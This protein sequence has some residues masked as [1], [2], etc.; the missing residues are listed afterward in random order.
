[1]NIIWKFRN[2]HQTDQT[3]N[4]DFI[5]LP[6]FLYNADVVAC[7]IGYWGYIYGG[8]LTTRPENSLRPY[9]NETKCPV[10]LLLL[11]HSQLKAVHRSEGVVMPGEARPGVC[12]EVSD[13][14][15]H[16]SDNVTCKGQV[17]SLSVPFLSFDGN[18]PI[19]LQAV[20]TEGRGD[21]PTLS[22]EEL[23]RQINS[24]L[25]AEPASA[26]RVPIAETL[27]K[28]NALLLRH[29]VNRTRRMSDNVLYSSVRKHLLEN[30]ALK[31]NDGKVRCGLKDIYPI[32]PEENGWAPTPRFRPL[33]K[34]NAEP[35]SVL[36]HPTP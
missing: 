5:V 7:N 20:Q 13:L 35:A 22:Q 21:Y 10:V 6:G 2:Y 33:L 25:K 3:I 34:R 16:L 24:L 15:I 32:R 4:Q 12:C 1:E 17:Y 8:L 26:E 36:F 28:E 14:E 31:D 23:F 27:A 11:D 19:S 18:K 30:F 9:L 29:G